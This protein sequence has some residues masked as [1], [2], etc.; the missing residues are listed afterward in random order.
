M[1][2]KVPWIKFT[3]DKNTWPGNY[4]DVLLWLKTKDIVHANAKISKNTIWFTLS[5][6]GE[7]LNTFDVY[8]WMPIWF[9]L[10]NGLNTKVYEKLEME[11]EWIV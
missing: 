3:K 4:Q 8:A 10:P 11:E 2:R 5:S 6:N 9:V 7:E 1:E